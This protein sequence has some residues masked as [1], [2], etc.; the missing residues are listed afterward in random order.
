MEDMERYGD[1]NEIDAPPSKNPVIVA[2]KIL[3]GIVCFSVIGFLAFRIFLFNY[4][5]SSMT[6]LYFN[7]T[8]SEYYNETGGDISVKTQDLRF[9]YDDPNEGNFFCDNLFVIYG[10]E[11]LQLSVRFNTAIF[12]DF[13]TKYGVDISELGADAFVFS[14]VRDPVE[15][16]GEPLEIGRLDCVVEDSFLM[17]RYCKLVFDGIDFGLDSG[18]DKV[19]WIRLEIELLGAKEKTVFAVPVYENNESFSAFDDYKLSSEEIP[20]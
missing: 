14:L 5:P 7:S 1:Y 13:K 16:N 2:L 6:K 4:Y 8:L 12:R 9:P 3:V 10:A 19:E 18:A 17:Y 15:E 11:Q 20:Q